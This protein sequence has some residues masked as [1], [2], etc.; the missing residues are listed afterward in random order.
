MDKPKA[1]AGE[2][3]R[4][5]GGSHSVEFGIKLDMFGDRRVA[6]VHSR[7]QLAQ[8]IAARLVVIE[9]R[10]GGNHQLGGYFASR[11]TA[12]PVGERQ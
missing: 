5:E 6:F 8:Q 12:H 2:Q 11:M 10:Q 7:F 4:R 9:M 3:Y 1:I